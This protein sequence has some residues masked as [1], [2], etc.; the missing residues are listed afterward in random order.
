MFASYCADVKTLGD[1]VARDRRTRE[2]ALGAD[3]TPPRA[4]DYHQFC[5]MAHRTSN[6]F[7]HQGVREG[8]LVAVTDHPEPVS[9]LSLFGA[10]LLGARVRFDPARAVEAR[11]LVSPASV[12]DYSLAPGTRHVVYGDRPRDPQK[13]HFE[14]NV[15]SE[16]P[17]ALPIPLAPNDPVLVTDGPM[18]DHQTL[19]RAAR[20]VVDEWEIGPT[21]ELVV[22]TSLGRP[23]TIVAGILAPLSV[24]AAITLA[25]REPGGP[26]R[27]DGENRAAESVILPDDVPV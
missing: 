4:Y 16:N 13:V 24:G 18:Y 25:S 17:A 19:L 5:T 7:R 12:T 22:P 2:P 3:G 23:G 1:L 26:I 20:A 14:A 21:D 6:F 11:L 8:S 27:V 15:P 9:I 10:A